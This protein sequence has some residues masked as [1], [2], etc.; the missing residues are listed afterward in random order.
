MTP[1]A[2]PST[3]ELDETLYQAL[4]LKAAAMQ[5]SVADLVNEAVQASLAED[6]EDLAEAIARQEE[7]DEPFD[8]FLAALQRDGKI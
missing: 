8:Q 7:P 4:Q 2:T 1:S 3:V 6:A 5:S